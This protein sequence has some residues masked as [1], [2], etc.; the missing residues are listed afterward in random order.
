[1]SSPLLMPLLLVC[2]PSSSVLHKYASPQSKLNQFVITSYFQGTIHILLDWV[3]I[4]Y[5]VLSS[6]WLIW[7]GPHHVRVSLATCTVL[8]YVLFCASDGCRVLAVHNPLTCA[9]FVDLSVLLSMYEMACTE[10]APPLQIHSWTMHGTA[11][12]AYHPVPLLVC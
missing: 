8:S 4:P 2:H 1:V 3:C 7:R 5:L 11:S 10:Q 9:G 6:A 12:G